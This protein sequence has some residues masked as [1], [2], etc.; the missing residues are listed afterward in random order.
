MGVVTVVNILQY[1]VYS[2]PIKNPNCTNKYAA[3]LGNYNVLFRKCDVIMLPFPKNYCNNYA[4][5][6]RFM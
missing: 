2:I 1:T 4:A 6:I 3:M 5:A